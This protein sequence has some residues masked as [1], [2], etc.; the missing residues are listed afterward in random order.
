MREFDISENDI[1][2]TANSFDVEQSLNFDSDLT[3]KFLLKLEADK[4]IGL[5]VCA[6]LKGTDIIVH[7]AYWILQE[8]IEEAHTNEPLILLQQLA[9][10]FGVVIR[11][12]DHLNRFIF[13]EDIPLRYN[14]TNN[15]VT[16]TEKDKNAVGS[17]L[18]KIIEIDGGHVARC[19]LVFFIHKD[20]YIAWLRGDQDNTEI[21]IKIAPQI[22]HL[23]TYFDVIKAEGT[24][25][26]I[27]KNSEIAPGRSGFLFKVKHPEYLLECGFADNSAYIL[28]NEFKLEYALALDKQ[29]AR[30][31]YFITWQPTHISI[32]AL[33]LPE[34]AEEFKKIEITDVQE[35]T[36]NLNTRTMIPPNSLLEWARKQSIA[37]ITIYESEALFYQAVIAA[38]QTINDKVETI[39]MHNPFW[40][41][42]YEAGKVVSRQPKREVDIHP[43]IHG[44]LYDISIA[45]N[46]QII[47]E[48]PVA[49]GLLDFLIV[50][51]I[52]TGKI[53]SICI[54]FKHAH[55][56]DLD[57]GFT[58]QLPK[59]MKSKG[60]DL[61]VYCVLFFK[62]R[63][64]DE[65]TKFNNEGDIEVH[66][67]MLS[68]RYGLSKIRPIIFDFSQTNPPS[69]K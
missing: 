51:P 12:G 23:V 24:L 67:G 10:R 22:R 65:P 54:E 63:Y 36:R 49:G 40:D 27:M 33:P 45:K 43:T 57:Q 8:L 61:G 34:S 29:N 17:Q 32:T 46:F 47:R 4:G 2:L 68:T 64:F 59:Y 38:L 3:L 62:G 52:K 13:K 21:S 6:E 30:Q 53:A 25:D 69:T 44:L 18:I 39:G 55:S 56:K 26:L 11:V 35:K 7:A 60:S 28:H 1:V 66:L 16:L 14:Q 31:R 15:I 19:A 20:G 5:I 42:T 48:Y 9:A 58:D 41:I 37:P 50:G